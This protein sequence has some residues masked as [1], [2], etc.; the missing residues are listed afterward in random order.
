LPLDAYSSSA[1]VLIEGYVPRSED[2]KID[3]MYT[4]AAPNYFQTIGTPIVKGREFEER[5]REGMPGV[6]IVNESMARLYW[7]QQDP[8]GK[9]L[10]LRRS[11][12]PFLEVIGV[13]G[14]GKYITLGED[15]MPYMFLPCR[16]SYKSRMT[17]LIRSQADPASL[18][19]GLRREVAA[20]DET[21]PVFG[22][23]TMPQF[24][25]RSL[26]AASNVAGL[27]GG[28][29]LAA[30]L[31]AAVGIYGLMS[32]SV[33]QRTRE[34]GIRAA[35]GAQPGDVLRL[36]AKQG[37]LLALVG[38]AF[39]LAGAFALTRVMSSMLL[40]T[41]ATD[42]ATFSVITVLLALVAFLACYIPARRATKVD[43]MIALRY[44]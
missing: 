9:R 6:V 16:Q 4:A 19:T 10:Q 40:A 2:E 41:S 36:V 8:I 43:P 37:M 29:G 14:D 7:P 1:R 27:V 30:L 20:L 39:G 22:I 23:K 44:E 25:E 3:V 24:M 13:A 28:F 21:L 34:I 31:L 38:I 15:P 17:I 18:A 5:D 11:S 35:L 12:G 33:A 26:W 32:Y 42:P